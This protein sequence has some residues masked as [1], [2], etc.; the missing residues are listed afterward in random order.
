[1]INLYKQDGDVLYGI[2]EFLLDS[3]DDV[4]NL[5]T[6][7]KTGSTALVI[8]TGALYMLNGH[9]QWIEV[10]GTGGA[11]GNTSSEEKIAKFDANNNDLVDSL[12]LHKF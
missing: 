6:N 8:P 1:M 11:G 3:Q 5:P 4:A 10:G 2:K 9:R 12:E 7:I